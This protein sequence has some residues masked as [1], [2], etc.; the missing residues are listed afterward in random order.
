MKLALRAGS[1]RALG[2]RR[3]ACR[4][5]V[6]GWSVDSRTHS[7][8]DL[9]FALRGPNHDGHAYVAEALEK[10]AA[11]AVVERESSAAALDASSRVDDTL[12]GACS[13]WPRGRAASGAGPWSG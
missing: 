1:P 4:R 11:A 8:G 9:F 12:R 2:E 13:N 6:T 7:P 5:Q 10:G 3:R